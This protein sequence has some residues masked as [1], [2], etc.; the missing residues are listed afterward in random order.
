MTSIRD[1]PYFGAKIGRHKRSGSK[2]FIIYVRN[3]TNHMMEISDELLR[4][5]KLAE[6]GYGPKHPYKTLSVDVTSSSDDI[7]KAYR[8][9]ALM[10]HPDKNPGDKSNANLACK[11]IN[12]AYEILCDSKKRADFNSQAEYEEPRITIPNY[13]I[14]YDLFISN[15][16]MERAIQ[17]KREISAYLFSEGYTK[18]NIQNINDSYTVNIFKHSKE[19]IHDLDHY[20]HI[21]DINLNNPIRYCPECGRNINVSDDIIQCKNDTEDE[22]ATCC[23]G[24]IHERCYKKYLRRHQKKVLRDID[25]WKDVDSD[26]W[27]CVDCITDNN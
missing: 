18:L 3:A 15:P 2:I 27:L 14:E 1:M 4:R 12:A 24:R 26:D 25:D 17:I 7:K 19:I 8:K 21:K 22:H 20:L 5:A 23:T 16:G 11:D 9:L 13:T 10:F 6:E